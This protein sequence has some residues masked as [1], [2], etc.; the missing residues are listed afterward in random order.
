MDDASVSIAGRRNGSE[1]R[2]VSLNS[3]RVHRIRQWKAFTFFQRSHPWLVT[4][5]AH[6]YSNSP[7]FE[8]KIHQC[9]LV[10]IGETFSG[11]GKER[12][13]FGS[14]QMIIHSI[15]EMAHRFELVAVSNERRTTKREMEA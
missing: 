9:Q 15:H 5:R 6:E 4:C 1:T 13:T 2:R 12:P 7:P 10:S 8:F 14:G 11:F 3:R